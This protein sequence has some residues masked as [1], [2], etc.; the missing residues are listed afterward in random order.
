MSKLCRYFKISRAGYY[1]GQ[2]RQVRQVMGK[3]LVVDMI[4]QERRLQPRLGGRK[5]YYMYGGQIHGILPRMGRDKF[6][7]LLRAEGLLVSRKR[8][9]TR[10][11]DS[12]HRF[13]CYGNLLKAVEVSRPNQ[14]W[15]TDITYLRTRSGFCYLSLARH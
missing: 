2:G 11:T 12:Y 5:L 15:V 13:H 8:S 3:E 9:Y 1:K 4:V 14:A 6:F 10:T 7:G